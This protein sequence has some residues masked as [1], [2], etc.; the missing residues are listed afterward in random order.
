MANGY[1]YHENRRG[2]KSRCQNNMRAEG[3]RARE[4]DYAAEI[5]VAR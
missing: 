1:A 3:V 5:A 4:D 2:V